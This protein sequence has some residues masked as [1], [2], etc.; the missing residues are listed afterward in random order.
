ML[1]QSL[2]MHYD[3]LALSR[4]SH[5][6]TPLAA[7]SLTS[8]VSPLPLSVCYNFFL[9]QLLQFTS[10]LFLFA[11]LLACNSH[12]KGRIYNTFKSVTHTHC[13]SGKK[14]ETTVFCFLSPML[15]INNDNYV[16]R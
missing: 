16:F 8:G 2:I 6:A 12:V 7:C 10:L 11:M 3:C 1:G 15:I 14:Q 4:T 13:G 5:T 9:A